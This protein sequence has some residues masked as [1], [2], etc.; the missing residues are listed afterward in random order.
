LHPDFSIILHADD[1]LLIAPSTSELQRLFSSFEHKL[2]WLNVRI[3]MK[4]FRCLRIGSI[5]NVCCAQITSSDGY[6]IPIL[7]YLGIH[8]VAAWVIIKMF[9]HPCKTIF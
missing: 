1:I 5:F 3:N 6:S 8:I 2:E 4:N 7:L 9:S